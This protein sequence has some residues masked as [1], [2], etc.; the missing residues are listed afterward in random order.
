MIIKRVSE[1][2]EITGIKKLQNENLKSTLKESER[3]EEGFVT[4]EYSVEF[5]EY[6]NAIEPSVIAKVENEI[7]GYALVT[8]KEIKGKH[9]LL[10]DLF[11]EIDKLSYNNVLLSQI[12]YVVV[13]QLCV[14]KKFRGKGLAQKLYSFF[15]EELSHKY[16][17][18]LTDVDESNPRS[19]QAHLKSG[20]EIIGTLQY[21]G[22][23]WH[24]VL[25]NWNKK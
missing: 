1:S 5:L 25:W 2:N 15:K 10:D 23:C 14:A 3:K 9:L 12:N 19:I 8:T 17:Y 18:C 21:G 11:N 22:S 24:I 13:G 20:F 7:V 6:M 16:L 4:A